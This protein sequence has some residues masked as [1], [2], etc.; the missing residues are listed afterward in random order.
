MNS[1]LTHAVTA[2]SKDA[3]YDASAKRLLGQKSILAHI[4]EK[5]V[6]EF[7]GMNPFDIIP[8]IEGDPFIST[9]PIEPGLTNAVF[10]NNGQRIIGFNSENQELYEGLARFDIIFYVRTKDGLS[11]SLL[12]WKLR[13]MTLLNIIF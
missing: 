3:Q 7:K 6:E 11:R 13:K 1:D 9:V 2:T 4:L 12:M 5:T 8:Q 10:K